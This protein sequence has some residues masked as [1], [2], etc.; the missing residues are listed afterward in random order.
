MLT[1]LQR[2]QTL[3]LS[4]INSQFPVQAPIKL[5]ESYIA[6]YERGWDVLRA[7]RLQRMKQLGLV[8]EKLSLPGLS[9]MDRPNISKRLKLLN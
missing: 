6:T 1:R 7:E 2:N 8:D 3:L 4:F 9:P 5:T